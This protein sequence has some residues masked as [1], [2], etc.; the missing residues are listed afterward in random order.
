[1]GSIKDNEDNIEEHKKVEFLKKIKTVLEEN[2]IDY[3]IEYGTLLGYLREK[4][5]IPWDHDIDLVVIDF[6]K[7]KKLLPKFKKM[8][9]EVELRWENS[10]YNTQ[11]I[12][13]KAPTISNSSFHV[14]IYEFVLVRGKPARKETFRINIIAKTIRLFQSRINISI[15]DNTLEDIAGFFSLK[16]TLIFPKTETKLVNFYDMTVRIPKNAEKHVR[17]LYGKDWKIPNK[18]QKNIE[19]GVTKFRK[20]NNWICELDE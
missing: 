4:R 1:V 6:E 15:I 7:V 9:L 2:R 19:S 20:R 12:Q 17:F 11:L 3:W 10:K 5:I 16:R 8:K 18:Y 13:I 14:D